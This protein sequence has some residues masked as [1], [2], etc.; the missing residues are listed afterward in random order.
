[1]ENLSATGRRLVV[2]SLFDGLQSLPERQGLRSQKR[3][4][5]RRYGR[6]PGRHLRRRTMCR[7]RLLI[8]LPSAARATTTTFARDGILSRRRIPRQ[9]HHPAAGQYRAGW[10]PALAPASD[11]GTQLSQA[12]ASSHPRPSSRTSLAGTTKSRSESDSV[13]HLVIDPRSALRGVH[14]GGM[15]WQAAPGRLDRERAL[16][17]GAFGRRHHCQHAKGELHRGA[18]RYQLHH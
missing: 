13:H 14:I 1:M 2:F 9:Q 16:L 11:R 3:R 5:D 17:R 4:Q 10:Q 12:R 18:L 6:Y 15:H 7:L 8:A